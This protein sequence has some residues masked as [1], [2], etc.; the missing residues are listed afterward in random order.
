MSCSYNDFEQKLASVVDIKILNLMAKHW[1]ISQMQFINTLMIA[2]QLLRDAENEGWVDFSWWEGGEF[3][4]T[5]PQPK[6][7]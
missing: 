2:G 3:T 6:H 7:R 1:E 4:G 5:L